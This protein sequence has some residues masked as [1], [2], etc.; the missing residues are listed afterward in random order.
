MSAP[1]TAPR[2]QYMEWVA[3]QIEEYK[4]GRTRDELLWLADVAVQQLFDSPD[5][6]YPLPEL[7]LRDAVDTFLFRKLQLPDYRTWRRA[8]QTVTPSR[9][10]KE[11]AARTIRPD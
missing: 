5:G 10:P 3:E 1:R 9:H 11:T 8:C 2:Q 6:P 7:L 4:A